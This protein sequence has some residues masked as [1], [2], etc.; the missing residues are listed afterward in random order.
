MIILFVVSLFGWILTLNLIPSFWKKVSSFLVFFIFFIFFD[1]IGLLYLKIVDFQSISYDN[2]SS[3]KLF[4]EKLFYIN[5]FVMWCLVII[6]TSFTCYF[7]KRY[8]LDLNISFSKKYLMDCFKKNIYTFFVCILFLIIYFDN[9]GFSNLAIIKV[10]SGASLEEII[11]ARNNS[12]NLVT[13]FH[14]YKFFFRDLLFIVLIVFMTVK[15]FTTGIVKYFFI[16]F[17]LLVLIFTSL[18]TGE[19]ATLIDLIL[20]IFLIIQM[21]KN[22]GLFSFRYAFI[23]LFVSSISILLTYTLFMPSDSFNKLLVGIFERLTV[24]Q[25]IPGIYYLKIFP[26]RH[27][28][29]MGQSFPNPMGIFPYDVVPLTE[30]V[31]N[32]SGYNDSGEALGVIGTMPFLFW[33][34]MYANFS[35]F[36][37]FLG[38]IYVSVL[39]LIVDVFFRSLISKSIWLFAVY[40]YLIVHL[41]DLSV[42]GLF[43]FIYDFNLILVLFFT[44]LL[45][46][47]LKL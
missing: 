13:R 42:T 35:Y 1:Y 36:G 20:L 8:N 21:N 23:F 18:M 46:L 47:R 3:E 45:R 9:V 43:G 19:K 40:I 7:L 30:L 16:F 10:I 38:V 12:G 6:Y 39:F 17:T 37:I 32:F 27:D 33:G 26:L 34:E 5:T 31:M 22:N 25:N 15:N 44:F 14:W 41:K 29:L 24:G 11:I 28:F 2:L 4:F